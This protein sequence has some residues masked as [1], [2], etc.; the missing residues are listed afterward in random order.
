LEVGAADLDDVGE[1]L[2]LLVKGLVQVAQRG[3]QQFVDFA[4]RRDMHGGRK[5]VIRGLAAVDVVVRMHQRRLTE[6]TAERLVGEVRDNL[7]GVHIGLRAGA[8]LPDYKRKFVVV[9]AL[10]DLGRGPRNGVS[11]ARFE[12]AQILVHK[13]GRLLDEPERVNERARHA[14]HADAEI[15]RRALRLRAPIAVGR[16]FDRP[17]RIAFGAGCG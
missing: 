17:K 5:R 1:R 13:R 2:R 11:E 4:C 3:Q 15:L 14:L 12:D 10:D 9:P 6:L 16:D 7:I 8:G